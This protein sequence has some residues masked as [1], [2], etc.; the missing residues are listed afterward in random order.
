MLANRSVRKGGYNNGKMK[1]RDSFLLI[2]LSVHDHSP[3]DVKFCNACVGKL[4]ARACFVDVLKCFPPSWQPES[5]N[6]CI[7][8]YEC[9]NM[10]EFKIA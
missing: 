8:L 4:N 5:E 9:M 7:S 2:I 1:E 6:C 10:H 3:A